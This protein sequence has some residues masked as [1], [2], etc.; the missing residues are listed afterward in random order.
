MD[1][2]QAFTRVDYR[3]ELMSQSRDQKLAFLAGLNAVCS[4]DTPHLNE[5]CSWLQSCIEDELEIPQR[6]DREVVEQ[7]KVK[8]VTYQHEKIKCGKKTCKCAKG[9]LHGPYWYSYSRQGGKLKTKYIGKQ[10]PTALD[11]MGSPQQ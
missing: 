10:R 6:G 1:F 5:L 2:Q 3:Q 9:N 4:N 7:R 11:V 8:G